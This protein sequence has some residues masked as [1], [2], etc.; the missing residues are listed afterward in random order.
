MTK[1]PSWIAAANLRSLADSGLEWGDH[2]NDGD[3]DLLLMGV[4][5]LEYPFRRGGGIFENQDGLFVG[6][7]TRS[8]LTE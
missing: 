2:D 5:E 7:S 1:E 6:V 3:L 4:S 8:S